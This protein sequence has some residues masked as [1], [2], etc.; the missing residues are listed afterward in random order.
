MKKIL[1]SIIILLNVLQ[2]FAQKAYFQQEA[3][4]VINVALDDKTHIAKGDISIEYT[5]H[6]PDELPY[7]YMH[8]WGNAFK[9]QKSAFAKQLLKNYSTDYYFSKPEEKGGYSDLDFKVNGTVASLEFDPK[10]PDIAKLMLPKALKPGEKITI[11]TPFTLRI[12]TSYSRFGHVGES[13]QMTQWFP[14]PAVYDAKGWHAMPYLNQGEFYSEFG[15]FDVSITLPSNYVVGATGTLETKSEVAFIESKILSSKSIIEKWDKE[16]RPEEMDFPASAT[17]MKTIRYTAEKIHDFAWF[18]DKRF[19]VAKDQ[20]KL[21]SGRVIDTY[22]MF[23]T[24]DRP[25]LWKR[26]AEYAARAVKAYSEWVGEYPYPHATAVQSALSAGAGMEYPM[27]TVIGKEKSARGLDNVITH[28][29]GHNWFYGILATNERDYPWMDEGINSYYDHRYN[30]VHYKES[31]NK[32]PGFVM[33]KTI[34]GLN[35]DNISYQFASRSRTDQAPQTQSADFEALNYGVCVYLKS[36]MVLKYLASYV[37]QAKF[38]AI[39]QKYYTDWQFKHPQPED[40]RAHFERETGEDLSWF[41]KGMIESND[42]MDYAISSIKKGQ[43]DTYNLTVKNNGNVNAPI[44]ISAFDDDKMVD[45]KWIKSSADVTQNITFPKGNY[46]KFVIDAER[47]APEMYRRNNLKFAKGGL[48]IDVRILNIFENPTKRSIGIAPMIN[49]NAYDKLML[50]GVVY[51]SIFPSAFDNFFAISPIYSFTTKSLNGFAYGKSNFYL[52][53]NVI[54]RIGII[55]GF[56]TYNYDYDEG[57]DVNIRYYKSQIKLEAEFRKP[58]ENDT[59]TNTLS[60]RFVNINQDFVTGINIVKKEY[61]KDSRAY[62]VHELQY[63]RKNTYVLKPSIWKSTIQLSKGF[64]KLMTDYKQD[65]KYER[66]NEMLQL[67]AFAGLFL[68]IKS[69]DISFSNPRFQV[70]G[71]TGSGDSQVDYLYDES[72]VGRSNDRNGLWSQQIYQRDAGLKTL[73]LVASSNTWL[74]GGGLAYQLPLPTKIKFKP[75]ADVAL[76]PDLTSNKPSVALSSGLAVVL[77]PEIFEVYFPIYETKNIDYA[78]RPKASDP[79]ASKFSRYTNKISFMLNL[80][81]I[82]YRSIKDKIHF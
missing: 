50:G 13:Y 56:K 66:K 53:N 18:A 69:N 45:S 21:K 57:Y 5:N 40:F 37:G 78:N 15:K 60:Y 52:K 3:N 41:F 25:D 81:A 29:V 2:V 64:T 38:D 10:N 72:M 43:D 65:F 8:L 19:L 61:N 36:A 24:S 23:T 6:S 32:I 11:A 75:Y 17:T 22:A 39:M 58:L 73:D 14:K 9:N 48:P 54:K 63:T 27:I 31:N 35:E 68:N 79:L 62:Q 76:F 80:N 20:V 77:L 16:T 67:H 30:S 33:D 7:I 82:N 74:V 1:F 34:G 59:R 70:S 49:Y 46:S 71:T 47:L 4:Y 28:E 42:K 51:S 44:K 12:P 26:G 55:G